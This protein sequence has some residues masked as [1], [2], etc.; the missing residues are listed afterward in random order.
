[1]KYD[2]I[3][4]G[5]GS[6]GCVVATRLSED[7]GKSVLLLEAGPDYPDFEYLPDDLKRGYNVWRSAYGPHSWDLRGIANSTQTEPMIIPRGKA[8]GGSSAINGQVVFRGVP[9]DYDNWASWGNDEWA[10]TNC[11]PYFRK[12]ENDWDHPGD[13]FH[14]NEGPL[15]IRRFK[16]EDWI[17]VSTAFYDACVGVGFPEDSDQNS[18]DSNGIGVRPLNNIDGVRMST[19]LTYLSQARHR[20]NITVRG[21]VTV[22][23]VLFA[24]PAEPGQKPK[25]VGV[26]AESGGEVFTVEGEQIIL[27]SGTIGSCQ[28]LLLSGVGP[29][30]ELAA[31]GI[32]SVHDLPGVGK[33]FCDHP[34][35]YMVFRGYGD[36]ADVETPTIQVGLRFST[37]GSPTRADF[38]I[39]PTLMTSEHR[40]ASVSYE[41][42]E[43]HWGL[44]V[45]L[46]NATSS[47][48]ITLS[49]PGPSRAAPAGLPVVLRS[50]RPG[51]DA[52][53]AANRRPHRRAPVHVGPHREMLNPTEAD[54]VSDD[55][56]DNWILRNAYTQHHITGTCKIGPASDPMAVVDQH[57]RVHGL[58]NLRVIDASVM[59]DVI[60]ANTNATTIMIA[61]RVSDWIK[62]GK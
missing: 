23:R 29:K 24:P 7:A 27:S 8:T 55:A 50:L 4:V 10:F 1:M 36:P 52:G 40:P 44:S 19:S 47:G 58:E 46:Q 54:F 6:A 2:Y 42:D 35:A 41:G 20:L 12:M 22:H 45:G 16:R 3:V 13:D 31:H 14:G 9:E 53:G 59:P 34:A 25:A 37:P 17:P 62:D 18:P 51:A 60:R 38:Q 26:Q 49:T 21:N 28:A 39:T 15:P 48:E 56:L 57:C 61:E 43:F 30:D 11:L 32:A 5:G 33:N